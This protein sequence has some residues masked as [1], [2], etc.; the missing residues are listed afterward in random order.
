MLTA[1]VVASEAWRAE[2]LAKAALP[3]RRLA[4]RRCSSTST[5]PRWCSPPTACAPRRAGPGSPPPR[6]TRRSH[7]DQ[8]TVVVQRPGRRHRRLGAAHGL[9]RLGARAV[10][11][12]QA[13]PG[14]PGVDP[15]PPPLPRRSGRHLHRR[16]RRLDHARHVHAASAWPT[17]SSRS[18]RRGA[19]VPWLGAW[20]GCTSS[21]PSSSHRSHGG[22]CPR[23][24]WR[25]IHVLSLP[26]FAVATIHFVAAGSDAG[27]LPAVA[28]I[29]LACLTV[30][31]LVT[32][33]MN[34]LR[35]PPARPTRL[36]GGP[37]RRP[38]VPPV[39]APALERE[40]VEV[41]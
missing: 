12:A 39:A 40:L 36:P 28:A 11:Q 4:P 34:R 19:R 8:P 10:H 15:R 16:P 5:S 22:T 35:R 25:R 37:E 21:P 17:C 30:V 1:S 18:P 31:A 32:H 38:L 27:T 20:S 3:R 41:P 14:P 23:R 24:W 2:V 33:R 29:T 26:L 6:P 7:H 9:R 13:A